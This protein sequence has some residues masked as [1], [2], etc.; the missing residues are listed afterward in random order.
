MVISKP[1]EGKKKCESVMRASNRAN[2]V[3]VILLDWLFGNTSLKGHRWNFTKHTR[4]LVEKLQNPRLKQ[5]MVVGI[6]TFLTVYLFAFMNSDTNFN[7]I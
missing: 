4:R 7:S 5:I 1:R 3:I 2:W 6:N